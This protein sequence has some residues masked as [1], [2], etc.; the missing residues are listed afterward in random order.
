MTT[1][2]AREVLGDRARFELINMKRALEFCEMLNTPEEAQRL[3]A[4]KTLLKNWSK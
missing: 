4:T 3:E 1:T 2:G